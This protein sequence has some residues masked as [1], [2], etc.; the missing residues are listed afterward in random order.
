MND[1]TL[2]KEQFENEAFKYYLRTDKMYNYYDYQNWIVAE[3]LKLEQGIFQEVYLNEEL[4]YV[5]PQE[6]T[7]NNIFDD[8][9]IPDSSGDED[10]ESEDDEGGEYYTEEELNNTVRQVVDDYFSE[11]K[12]GINQADEIKSGQTKI[13]DL[14]SEG[15][16]FAVYEGKTYAVWSGG[17]CDGCQALNGTVY[18]VSS[19]VMIGGDIPETHPNCKCELTI[20]DTNF[21]PTKERIPLKKWD[22]DQKKPKPSGMIDLRKVTFPNNY[23][24]GR[25]LGEEDG[26]QKKKWDDMTK[27]EQE[28]AKMKELDK[29][30]KSDK[31]K[32]NLKESKNMSPYQWYNSVRNGGKWDYKQGGKPEMEHAGNFNYGATG[33]AMLNGDGRV[34][35]PKFMTEQILLRGA[36]W[37]QARAGTSKPELGHYYKDAPYGDDSRDQEMIQKGID[38]YYD[39]YLYDNE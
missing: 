11:K 10:E 7:N 12:S 5:I 6:D 33:S 14:M 24:E 35:T 17:S 38:Y 27:A 2:T 28:K 13:D 26:Q 15:S 16:G 32:A 34:E 37:A 8:L 18:E 23:T 9:D 20:L 30:M 31:F 21:L 39:N 3:S 25:K 36:G 1:V 29:F 4:K 22:K 19:F